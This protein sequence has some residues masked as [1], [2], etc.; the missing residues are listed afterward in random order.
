[1]VWM[2]ALAMTLAADEGTAQDDM[3]RPMRPLTYPVNPDLSQGPIRN[4]F[5]VVVDPNAM[6]TTLVPVQSTDREQTEVLPIHNRTTGWLEVAVGETT[7]GVLGPL[8]LGFISNVSAGTYAVHMTNSAGYTATTHIETVAS[9]AT[10]VAPGNVD[11]QT[12]LTGEY[13]RPG[14][15]QDWMSSTVPV[16]YELPTATT[17]RESTNTPP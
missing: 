14:H 11:A 12:V 1:M 4:F 17:T 9:V 3:A 16:G 5:S 2:M 13:V 8:T 15:R 6:A 7:I 10:D